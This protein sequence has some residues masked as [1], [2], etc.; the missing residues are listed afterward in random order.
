MAVLRSQ[1]NFMN[2]LILQPL[3]SYE[4]IFSSGGDIVVAVLSS[5]CAS[6]PDQ[7]HHPTRKPL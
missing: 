4:F 6:Q 3:D 1:D 5:G 2:Y 7:F